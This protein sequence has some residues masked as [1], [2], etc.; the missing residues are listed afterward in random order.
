MVPTSHLLA[1]A[2]TS[3]VLIVIPGPS[4]L[5]TV[6]RALTF[7]RR[8]AFLSVLG[9][10]AGCYLQ[11]IAVACGVGVLV[12]RSAE[13]FTVVKLVGAAYLVYLGIQAIRHRRSLTEAMAVAVPPTRTGR[14]LRDG[15]VVGMTNPKTTV[16]FVA[17]LPQFIDRGAGHVP[18]Q[19]LIVGAIFPA[20]ALVSDSVWAYVAGT[21]RAW[22]ARSPKRLA[23]I[24]GAGGLAMIGLGTRLAFTGRKD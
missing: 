23:A 12:Q 20:I 5:F 10:A 15:V 1:F 4:V 6:S 2:L 24:G 11:V 14:M 8:G 22:F 7:G 18:L 16:F 19:L 17:L 9:N 21:A 3:F 13:I